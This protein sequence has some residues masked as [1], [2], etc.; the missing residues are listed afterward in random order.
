MFII[1]E[2]GV[3]GSWQDDGGN[4]D[5]DDIDDD[6]SFENVSANFDATANET[7]FSSTTTA[8]PKALVSHISQL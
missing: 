8:L 5:N 4:D 3:R 6:F 7:E 2:T 1:L